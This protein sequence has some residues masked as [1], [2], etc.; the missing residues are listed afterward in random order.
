MVKKLA[1]GKASNVTRVNKGFRIESGRAAKWDLLVATMKGK[2][3]DKKTGPEL[4]D[5]A[6]DL[7]FAKYKV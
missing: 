7:L 3:E 4:S 1:E 6:L 5:E 2:G